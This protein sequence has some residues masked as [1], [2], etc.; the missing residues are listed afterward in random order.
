M[1]APISSFTR[2]IAR[3]DDAAVVIGIFRRAVII[4]GEYR[5]PNRAEYALASHAMFLLE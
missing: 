1:S 4:F 3:N 2:V 5:R